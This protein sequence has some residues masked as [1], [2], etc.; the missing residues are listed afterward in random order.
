MSM[1]IVIVIISYPTPTP[2]DEL[3]RQ[4]FESLGNLPYLRR[5]WY[6]IRRE[7]KY[8]TGE[9]SE[10]KGVSVQEQHK[11]D[12]RGKTTKKEVTFRI[13]GKRREG[14][15]GVKKGTKRLKQKGG[16]GTN[17]EMFLLN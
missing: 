3:S 1:E 9:R 8:K 4:F 14:G 2:Q 12:K 13:K 17:V 7:P 10:V 11:K 16:D 6:K 15:D 5:E